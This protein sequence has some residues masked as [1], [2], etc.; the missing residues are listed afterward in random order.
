[1]AI[2]GGGNQQINNNLVYLLES[3]KYIEPKNT[4][5]GINITGLDR[6]DLMCPIDHPDVNENFSWQQDFGFG[7][8]N[9]GSFCNYTPPFNGKLQKNIGIE[10]V[11]LYN[12]LAIIQC[13]SYMELQGFKY[14]FMLMDNDILKDSP[15]WFKNFVLHNNHLVRFNQVNNMHDF[16]QI[17]C[18][19]SF[20]NLLRKLVTV[21]QTVI[22]EPESELQYLS[23]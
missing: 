7:W 23:K 3:K 6:V 19:K 13:F 14:F 20:T 22:A 10:Q 15:A 8:I 5:I 9:E 17:H 1:L 4:L 2:P 12:C 18:A 11:I 16:V 21:V